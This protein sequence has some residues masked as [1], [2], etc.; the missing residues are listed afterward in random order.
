MAQEQNK[1]LGFTDL[2]IW[3]KI[4]IIILWFAI[5]FNLAAFIIGFTIGYFGLG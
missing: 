3:L 1:K 5:I 2:N 4:P